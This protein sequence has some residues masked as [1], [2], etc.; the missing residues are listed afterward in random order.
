M[1]MQ[2]LSI[3]YALLLFIKKIVKMY[4]RIG[5]FGKLPYLHICIL[6]IPI[7]VSIFVL[8]RSGWRRRRTEEPSVV[9]L[10]RAGVR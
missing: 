5:L 3:Y 4:P 1:E 8:P 7:H 10:L 6:P 9:K 2:L